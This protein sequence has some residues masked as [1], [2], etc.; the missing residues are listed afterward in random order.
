MASKTKK[1]PTKQCETNFNK[2]PLT[3]FGVGYSL[4]YSDG[5]YP[6]LCLIC[7]V[8]LH[9]KELIFLQTDVS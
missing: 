7:P 8:K 3:Y 4:T 6:S 9:R 2:L 5:A 1:C